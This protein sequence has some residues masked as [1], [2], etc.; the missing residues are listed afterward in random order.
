M[1]Q[2]KLCELREVKMTL[3]G[4]VT[5]KATTSLSADVRASIIYRSFGS[6]VMRWSVANIAKWILLMGFCGIPCSLPEK[7]RE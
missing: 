3:F 2:T 1:G 4:V 6:Q 7:F 5:L